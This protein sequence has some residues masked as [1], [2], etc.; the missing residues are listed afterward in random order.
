M[1]KN[2]EWQVDP[3]CCKYY[4]DAYDVIFVDDK[5][6]LRFCRYCNPMS[7]NLSGKYMVKDNNQ[8]FDYI[9]SDRALCYYDRDYHRWCSNTSYNRIKYWEVIRPEDDIFIN[10]LVGIAIDVIGEIDKL[11][12]SKTD[13]SVDDITHSIKGRFGIWFD[14]YYHKKQYEGGWTSTSAAIKVPDNFFDESVRTP[15]IRI[16]KL[17]LCKN[18]VSCFDAMFISGGELWFGKYD[19][20]F[21][22]D[23]IYMHVKDVNGS[24]I[25]LH[26]T[27]ALCFYNESKDK[28]IS[29]IED[30]VYVEFSGFVSDTLK[31]MA[32][33]A[34]DELAGS[35]TDISGSQSITNRIK[36]RFKLWFEANK[37][38]GR[39]ELK[40][41][42]NE[43]YGI[44]GPKRY[45]DVPI[46]KFV[47]FN[48]DVTTVIWMDDT[49]TIVKRA[50]GEYY[51]EEKALMYAVIKR[52]SGNNGCAMRR[53]L[54][55]F[56]KHSCDI[57]N[58]KKKEK[59]N[60]SNKKANTKRNSGKA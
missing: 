43:A 53:Y 2:Y 47:Q 23:H 9:T 3:K 17:P 33:F 59:K 15:Q 25:T 7:V 36:N 38:Y 14:S 16:N 24:P 37:R 28:W 48:G 46:P 5:H 32:N 52:M 6:E 57:S 45:L 56:Y 54:N 39:S 44:K 40:K 1:E 58:K 42:L 4:L 11:T 10:V 26:R 60:G 27:E 30:N 50:E 22:S 13:L 12:G 41:T 55:C 18:Y 19:S 29:Q 35:K 34:I 20:V 49:H 8:I 31:E 51:D 21:A